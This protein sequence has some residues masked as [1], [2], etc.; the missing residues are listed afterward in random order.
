MLKKSILLAATLLTG[1][2]SRP[3]SAAVYGVFSNGSAADSAALAIIQAAGDTATVL[4]NLMVASLSG[5]NVLFLMNSSTTAELTALTTS[6]AA[7]NSFVQGGGVF[8]LNDRRVTGAAGVVPGATNITFTRS[9]GTDINPGAASKL[10][11]GPA[12]VI[13][14]T[15]LDGGGPSDD[16]YATILPAGATTLLTRT[17]AAR[18]VA[19]SYTLGA[20][21]VYYSTIPLDNY[22]STANASPAAFKTV[23]APNLV[24]YLDAL[25][26][27]AIPE[28]ASLAVLGMG[29]LG[30]RLARRRAA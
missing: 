18:A 26:P 15:T 9:T 19:F 3:A 27:A 22:L 14:A 1:L 28:P 12:G 21:S 29:L 10:V 7:I 2:A 25:V 20:G 11:N 30:L 23:Y 17:N 16:G 24:A 4:P 8:A 5:V 6:A 13:G